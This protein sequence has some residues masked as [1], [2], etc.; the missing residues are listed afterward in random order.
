[1]EVT[2]PISP[3]VAAP[4]VNAKEVANPEPTSPKS[5]SLAELLFFFL[6]TRYKLR[7]VDRNG[8]RVSRRNRQYRDNQDEENQAAAATTATTFGSA[9]S[10]TCIS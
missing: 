3:M 4:K 9:P 2:Q 1:M 7:V 8:T 5:W 6:R 10:S